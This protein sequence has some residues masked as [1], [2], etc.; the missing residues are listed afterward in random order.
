[1]MT[2]NMDEVPDKWSIGNINTGYHSV[3]LNIAS[4]ATYLPSTENQERAFAGTTESQF[5]PKNLTPMQ[6]RALREQQKEQQEK[7]AEARNLAWNAETGTFD[8][9]ADAEGE[10]DPDFVRQED[11]SFRRIFDSHI[12]VP[13]GVRNKAGGIES[14]PAPERKGE[15]VYGG[16]LE[17]V[18]MHLSDL[19]DQTPKATAEY[20]ETQTFGFDVQESPLPPS[21]PVPPFTMTTISSVHPDEDETSLLSKMTLDDAGETSVTDQDL[22]DPIELQAHPERTRTTKQSRQQT[23]TIAIKHTTE[24]DNGLACECGV[25]VDDESCFCEGGCARWL[26]TW[27]IGY[28]STDDKRMPLKFICIDCRLHADISWELIKSELYP[29]LM[30]KYRTLALFRRSIKV[31]EKMGILTPMNFAK[32]LGTDFSQSRQLLKRLEEEGFVQEQIEEIDGLGLV[33]S[34]PKKKTTTKQAKQRRNNIQKTQYRFQRAI[35]NTPD[36]CKYFDPSIEAE[37]KLLGIGEMVA[38]YRNHLVPAVNTA[39]SIPGPTLPVAAG[40]T[41]N[42]QDMQVAEDRQNQTIPTR[43]NKRS[44]TNDEEGRNHKKL[45]ISVTGGVDLAE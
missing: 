37:N 41:Q 4:I 44:F 23:R 22:T 43:H 7:D 19:N 34:R 40:D 12:L 45:K 11:G 25:S 26:H 39:S 3:N 29:R 36:Y 10:D 13:F 15:A 16:E 20:D 1:M 5:A 24:E 8:Q 32:Q 17:V 27:C 33:K 2:H 6:E 38:K 42:Q 14:I 21:D 31:A 18:P 35:I 30:S 28:H 9:D